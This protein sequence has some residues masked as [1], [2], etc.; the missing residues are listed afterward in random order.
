M[1]EKL[2][3]LYKFLNSKEYKELIKEKEEYYQNLWKSYYEI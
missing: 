3:K 2:I 1:F